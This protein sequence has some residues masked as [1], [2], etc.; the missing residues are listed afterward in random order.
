VFAG[1]SLVLR[2]VPARYPMPAPLRLEDLDRFLDEHG[3]QYAVTM[4]G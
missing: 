4:T 3:D 2:E 1:G